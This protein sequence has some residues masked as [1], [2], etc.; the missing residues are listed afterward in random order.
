MF[1]N[2]SIFSGDE[3]SIDDKEH[4]L[5]AEDGDYRGNPLAAT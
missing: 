4:W 3:L 1:S 2:T 5:G